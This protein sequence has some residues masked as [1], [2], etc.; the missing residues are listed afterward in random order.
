MLDFLLSFLFFVYEFQLWNL[1]ALTVSSTDH[2]CHRPNINA[3]QSCDL[4]LKCMFFLLGDHVDTD[5]SWLLTALLVSS[6]GHMICRSEQW[7]I[8]IL[9]YEQDVIRQ[10]NSSGFLVMSQKELTGFVFVFV[11]RGV[12]L[13]LFA[14]YNFIANLGADMEADDSLV[15]KLHWQLFMHEKDTY[16]DQDN[17]NWKIVIAVSSI[18]AKLSD[19]I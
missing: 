11:K 19:F 15:I 3:K 6:S 10:S 4:I 12:R 9:F 1:N 13:T 2:H 16:N 8:L 14:L 5:S 7:F 17:S 18:A